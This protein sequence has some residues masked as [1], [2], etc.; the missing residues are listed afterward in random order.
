MLWT[1]AGAMH[2]AFSALCVTL[3]A[4]FLL[5][6]CTPALHAPVRARLR[7]AAVWAVEQGLGWVQTA[8]RWQSPLL[9]SLFTKS[10]ASVSVT[11]YVR[12]PACCLLGRSCWGRS[13]R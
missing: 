13:E 7:P 11:F 1:L 6:V 9:T 5:L 8:Q 4:A 3:V 2:A 12:A 10:S